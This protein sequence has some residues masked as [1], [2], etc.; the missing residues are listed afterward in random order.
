MSHLAGD[1][2]PMYGIKNNVAKNKTPKFKMSHLYSIV[3]LK[4]VNEGDG[5]DIIINRAEFSVSGSEEM[6]IGEFNV[7][8]TGDAPIYSSISGNT[9]NVAKLALNQN[10]VIAKGED[11]AKI[12]YL[13]I[14]PFD[15]S[16]K[17]I[18]VII[19]GSARRV[20]MPAN[21]KFEAGK[22]TT[23]RIPVKAL[24]FGRT[25]N[26]LLSVKATYVHDW[27][28]WTEKTDAITLSSKNPQK[29]IVNGKEVDA[30]VLGTETNVGSV[31][32]KGTAKEL[33][34]YL[35][36]GFYVTS[37]DKNTAVM[38]VES[39][40]GYFWLLKYIGISFSYDELAGKLMAAERIT[41]KGVVPIEQYTDSQGIKHLTILDEEPVH[42]S[43]SETQINNLLANFDDVLDDGYSPTFEGLQAAITNPS[44]IMSGDY[45]LAYAKT[46]ADITAHIIYHKIFSVLHSPSNAESLGKVA[47]IAELIFSTPKTLFE[48]VASLPI[49]A[50]LQTVP[51]G[52]DGA[53]DNR[54]VV[55]GLSSS[56]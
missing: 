9:S 5:G 42:K 33:M 15:A 21:I 56:N 51:K 34:P 40:K 29:M 26:D 39:I 55:W 44:S 36:L 12:L 6:I 31:T 22:I 8:V 14:K 30:F 2:Y 20:K 25:T 13:A 28:L 19:N 16:G 46:Q 47:G 54:I 3:A 23:L 43:V 10:L 24:S 7:N 4:I 38:R 49:K 11:N 48:T 1:Y 53:T 17:T 35:P 52:T 27:E 45:T 50:T 37:W 32:I 41:F 18:D